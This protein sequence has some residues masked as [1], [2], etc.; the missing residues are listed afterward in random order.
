M[1]V[2]SSCRSTGSCHTSHSTECFT[3]LLRWL[4]KFHQ[5]NGSGNIGQC[6]F[7]RLVS[8][9][10]GLTKNIISLL[11]FSNKYSWGDRKLLESPGLFPYCTFVPSPLLLI[12]IFSWCMQNICL[13]NDPGVDY[14]SQAQTGFLRGLVSLYSVALSDVAHLKFSF[15]QDAGID[16]REARRVGEWSAADAWTELRMISAVVKATACSLTTSFELCS[17]LHPVP[18]PGD[19]GCLRREVIMSLCCVTVQCS[20]HCLRNVNPC[21]NESLLFPFLHVISE[22]VIYFLF[23]R[24]WFHRLLGREIGWTFNF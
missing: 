12:V 11:L 18:N 17:P 8:K 1:Q 2:P 13:V 22:R 19:Q 4:A 7:L 24:A 20:C 21:A 15:V 10:W 6:L 3:L 16:T 5:G 23:L 14:K 9:I